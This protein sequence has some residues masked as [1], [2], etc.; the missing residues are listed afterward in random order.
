MTKLNAKEGLPTAQARTETAMEKTT[1][2][3]KEIQDAEAQERADKAARLRR[4]R[5]EV[6]G[7]NSEKTSG[8]KS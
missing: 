6:E 5:L 4:A 3:V 2:A 1:R 8:S 7:S